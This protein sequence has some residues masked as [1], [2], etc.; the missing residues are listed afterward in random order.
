[1]NLINLAIEGD[2][3]DFIYV[4]SMQDKNP[5]VVTIVRLYLCLSFQRKGSG[6][7]C[8]QWKTKIS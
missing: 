1:M 6:F 4:D 7:D 2:S 5:Y 8:L 3:V